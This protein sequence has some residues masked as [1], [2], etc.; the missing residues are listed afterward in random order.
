VDE[1]HALLDDH[2]IKSQTIRQNQNIQ[3]MEERALAWERKILYIQKVLDVWVKV[4]T[5]FLYL[6]PIFSYEDISKTLAVEAEKFREVSEVWD[7]IM[8]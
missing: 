2:S 1:I 8:E 4:Q 6:E 3:F 5:T 7:E